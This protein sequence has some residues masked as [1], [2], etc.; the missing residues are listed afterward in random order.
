MDFSNTLGEISSNLSNMSASIE[1]KINQLEKAKTEII[2]EQKTSLTEIENI[3]KPE[4]EDAWKGNRAKTFQGSR[5]DAYKEIKEITEND[6]DEY[7]N[8]IEMLITSLNAQK[9]VLNGLSAAAH[10]AEKLLSKGE[11]AFEE[12]GNT[13]NYIKGELSK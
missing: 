2:D 13:I 3:L 6:Y 9:S 8:A 4:L 10:G 7:V 5:K 12:I 1:E 11:E